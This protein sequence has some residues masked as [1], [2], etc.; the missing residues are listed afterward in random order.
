MQSK[1]ENEKAKALD[2][3]AMAGEADSRPEAGGETPRDASR[4]GMS[5]F[6]WV[7]REIL[8]A[9]I[10]DA[11]KPVTQFPYRYVGKP[12]DV[13]L[14][15]SDDGLPYAEYE[16]MR[17]FFPKGGEM[18]EVETVFRCYLEDEGLTGFGRRT[19]SPHCYVTEKHRPEKGDVIVDIGCSEGFFARSFAPLAKRIYLFEAEEKWTVPLQATFRDFR[20]K[21]CY[22][23]KFVGGKTSDTEVR[24]EDIMPTRSDDVYFLKLDIEGAERAVLEAAR[25]FLSANKIKMSCCAYHRQDDGRYLTEFLRG[26]GFRTEYSQGWMLPYCSKKFPFFRRGVIYA[27]NF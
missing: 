12:R 22:T 20:E 15:T 13:K 25:D 17:V 2:C 16:G 11:Y 7:V 19:K 10:P 18:K 3:G 9:V 26:I 27:R 1:T 14:G 8:K 23:Q 6:K 5:T 24:L 4:Q 21:V